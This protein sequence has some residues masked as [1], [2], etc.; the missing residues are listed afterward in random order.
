MIIST[1][2]QLLV[3][4]LRIPLEIVSIQVSNPAVWTII[5]FSLKESKYIV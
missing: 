4:C 3:D 2:Y 5:L 1:Y